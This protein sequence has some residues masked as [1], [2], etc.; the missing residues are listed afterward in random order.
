M[1]REGSPGLKRLRGQGPSP[2]DVQEGSSPLEGSYPLPRGDEG[3]T[4]E[5]STQELSQTR[6]SGLAGAHRTLPPGEEWASPPKVTHTH[7][8]PP[9][10]LGPCT[11]LSLKS[12]R[13]TCPRSVLKWEGR[14]TEALE[15]LLE[16]NATVGLSRI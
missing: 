1:M 2:S 9:C 14:R 5:N 3:G 13:E 8:G 6:A 16:T 15:G 7:S 11:L 12:C 4:N 10:R